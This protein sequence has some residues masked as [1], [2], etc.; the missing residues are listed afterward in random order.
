VLETLIVDGAVLEVEVV[1]MELL[2][3]QQPLLVLQPTGITTL[4]FLAL[5]L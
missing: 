3:D 4:D 2:L 1:Q 5:K